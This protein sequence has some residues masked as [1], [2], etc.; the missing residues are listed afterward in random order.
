MVALE[1]DGSYLLS[2]KKEEDFD[3]FVERIKKFISENKI[4]LNKIDIWD[5]D[6]VIGTIDW[7]KRHQNIMKA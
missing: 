3:Q 6:I 1:D 2:S 4:I 5:G 7:R